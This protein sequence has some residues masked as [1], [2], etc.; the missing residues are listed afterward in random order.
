MVAPPTRRTGS[1]RSRPRSLDRALREPSG[2][3]SPAPRRNP[4]SRT[5]IRRTV[6]NR[7]G[8]RPRRLMI[9]AGQNLRLACEAAEPR[10]PDHPNRC[11]SCAGLD[12]PPRTTSL[13]QLRLAFFT[14]AM[15]RAVVWGA[16]RKDA[17]AVVRTTGLGLD[18]IAGRQKHRQQCGERQQRKSLFK[19]RTSRR[20]GRTRD[21]KRAVRRRFRRRPRSRTALTVSPEVCGIPA[22]PGTTEERVAAAEARGL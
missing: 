13:T 8:A 16:R 21:I 5:V 22:Q 2:S 14:S 17:R 18:R 10:D 3:A 19:L 1:A 7:R 12:A 4:R 6:V 9:D 20:V 15:S 11:S